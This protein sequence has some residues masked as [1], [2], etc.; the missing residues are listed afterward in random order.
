MR[1]S[2]SISYPRSVWL[3]SIVILMPIFSVLAAYYQSHLALLLVYLMVGAS[4]FLSQISVDETC[5]KLF[6]LLLASATFSLLMTVNV[7]SPYVPNLDIAQEL[8][9]F[10]QVYSSGIW[11][12][13]ISFLYNSALSVSI[14][15][16][17]ISAVSSISGTLVF[18]V[19]FP[20]IYSLVPILLYKIYRKMMNPRL[21]FISVFVFL[22]FPTTY[23]ELASLGRQM[24]AE[25][26]LAVLLLVL[27]TKQ[28]KKDR[29]GPF[30][31]V[32]LTTGLVI[33]HYSTALIYLFL[34]GIAYVFW[35]A[36]K[37]R[38]PSEFIS[39]NLVGLSFVTA[40]AWFFLAASGIVLRN[41]SQLYSVVSVG[42]SDLFST[43]TVGRSYLV[44]AAAGVAPINFGILHLANRMIQ[45]LMVLLISV[46]FIDCIRRQTSGF[47]NQTIVPFMAPSMI[48]LGTAITIPFFSGALGLDRIYQ[49]SLFALA[50][51]FYYGASALNRLVTV[52]FRFPTFPQVRIR[53]L[54]LIIL[55]FTYLIFTSG[56]LW[57]VTLDTPTSY[58]LDY[59]RSA[60]SSIAGLRFQ[61]YD[62]YITAPD[63]F[64]SHW[65]ATQGTSVGSI[66]ADVAAKH[67]VLALAGI[68]TNGPFLPGTGT[69]PKCQAND[70]A[71]VSVLNTVTGIE[72]APVAYSQVGEAS[73]HE[74]FH[75]M[76][77][78]N[79]SSILQNQNR[80]YSDGA[81]IYQ[82]IQ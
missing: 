55:L 59:Q 51:C 2:F 63:V 54:F 40:L 72:T 31:T 1:N 30:L 19:V 58:V 52:H 43:S 47:R 57:S 78:N 69:Y 67:G 61:H 37:S 6:P 73:G 60:E 29:L 21:S 34:I 62:Y 41:I 10:Q 3:S 76:P 42:I 22:S 82:M 49:L 11:V 24:I 9:L 28:L 66:C 8:A 79:T 12:P 48:L 18:K 65:L 16:V 71:Y 32:I 23:T 75:L 33:S 15:P 5:D 70:Y 4:V 35:L 38:T 64:A 36:V 80:I 44:Y 77:L 68:D 7:I 27:L 74:S 50:P 20:A 13:S 39:V 53:R 45:Y 17:V 46:G 81:S 56:W 26:I 14:L 25:F